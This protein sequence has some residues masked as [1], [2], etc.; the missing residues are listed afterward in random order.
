MEYALVAKLDMIRRTAR[1]MFLT[2]AVTQIVGVLTL[3]TL[4]LRLDG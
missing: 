3:A 1:W 2:L 4:I